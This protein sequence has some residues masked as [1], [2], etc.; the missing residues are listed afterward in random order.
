MGVAQRGGSN[1]C[2]SQRE[3]NPLTFSGGRRGSCFGSGGRRCSC[4][5][6]WGWKTSTGDTEVRISPTGG[7]GDVAWLVTGD[8]GVDPGLVLRHSCV[9][10]WEICLGT[11]VAKTHNA[12]LDPASTLFAHHWTS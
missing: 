11:P 6:G 7:E 8:L 12:R 1:L 10:S 4:G 9:H 5:G 3:V 2:V